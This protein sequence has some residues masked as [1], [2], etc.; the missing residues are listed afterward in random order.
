MSETDTDL[1]LA[2]KNFKHNANI[3]EKYFDIIEKIEQIS[4]VR[5]KDLANPV[6]QHLVP[7]ALFS[8][9][10]APE[11]TDQE[12]VYEDEFGLK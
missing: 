1:S 3:L 5:S 4:F 2:N 10:H 6:L 11:N 7:V 12:I 9:R 8:M